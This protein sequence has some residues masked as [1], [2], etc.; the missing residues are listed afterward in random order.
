[1]ST[2]V[3]DGAPLLHPVA[4]G[5]IG[6]L[7]VNDHVLKARWPGWLTGKLS[8]VAGMVFFPLLLFVIVSF[9]AR[10][11]SRASRAVLVACAGVTAIAFAA[12]KTWPVATDAFELALGALRWPL[13][14]APA[15]ALGEQVPALAR[16]VVVRDASDLL[17]LPFV[18]VAVG[19]GWRSRALST[20]GSSC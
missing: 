19:I 10:P 12:V 11:P 20:K 7:L 14:A 5:A 1:M 18:A 2:R 13:A 4:L 9:V 15:L 3:A 8:D 17:A 6:L 16:A